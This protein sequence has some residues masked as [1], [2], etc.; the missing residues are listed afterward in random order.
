MEL[1]LILTQ[2]CNAQCTHCATDCGPYHTQTLAIEKV[3]ALMDDAARLTPA[4]ERL[5]FSLSGGEPFL[6]LDYLIAIVKY[7]SSLGA[8]VS[9]VTN[10]FWASS[11]LKAQAI[12]AR[13]RSAGLTRIAASTSRFHQRFVPIER[14]QRALSAARVAGIYTLLK[15]AYCAEDTEEGLVQ[16]WEEF[17]GADSLQAFPIAPYLRRGAGLPETSFVKV[18]GLPEGR[19]PSPSLT[20]RE[21]GRAY[22]C[23]TPGAFEP[24]LQLGSIHDN[25]LEDIVAEFQFGLV[26]QVLREAGPRYFAEYAV[27]R[28]QGSRLRNTYVDEC[29]LCAHIAS[30]P[31]LSR[32][33]RTCA[34]Q[35]R[36][37]WASRIVESL[38]NDNH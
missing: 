36:K 18:T 25:S 7:G 38:S 19:C 11:D 22:T 28:G 12:V 3:A 1:G 13:V 34:R 35:Y 26:L 29:D 6:D 23:C 17:V 32:T 5:D 10:A 37:D 9:C 30:D 15:V 21:D 20:I 24:L 27:A 4:G 16:H 31:A 2:R 33:A 14:V 8:T